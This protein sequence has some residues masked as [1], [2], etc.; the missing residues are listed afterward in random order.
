[1]KKIAR[2]LY[3]FAIVFLLAGFGIGI[4]R[5]SVSYA[6]QAESRQ[7]AAVATATPE[8]SAVEGC[9]ILDTVVDPDARIMHTVAEATEPVMKPASPVGELTEQDGQIADSIEKTA[10]VKKETAQPSMEPTEEPSGPTV[11]PTDSITQT[12]DA[13]KETSQPADDP[14]EPT[15]QPFDET[16]EP[17]SP[18]AHPVEE[19]KDEGDSSDQALAAAIALPTAT[20]TEAPETA[21]PT[22]ILPTESLAPS[23]EIKASPIAI[24]TAIPV[25][26][27]P[28]PQKAGMTIHYIGYCAANGLHYGK[29]TNTGSRPAELGYRYMLGSHRVQSLG[30]FRPGES[31]IIGFPRRGIIIRYYRYDHKWIQLKGYTR[32]FGWGQ[33]CPFVTPTP[34]SVPPTA[35]PTEVPPTATPTEVPPT[36][37]PT[38]VPPTETPTEV[39]PTETPTEVP[40]TETPTE[41]PPTE[42]P[43]EVPPTETPT[44][45]PPTETPTEVPPTETPTEVPPTETPTEVPPTETPTEVPPTETPTEVPPTEMPTEIPPTATPTEVP[46]TETPTEVP[47]ATKVSPTM[48]PAGALPTATPIEVQSAAGSELPIEGNISIR[49][50]VVCVR[51][52]GDG[53]FAAF[54]GYRNDNPHTVIIPI[55]PENEFS[56]APIN[57]GQPTVFT[58]STENLAD[59]GVFEVAFADDSLKW[60]V[61]GHMAI[62]DEHAPVCPAKDEDAA[63]S[64]ASAGG[65]ELLIPVTGGDQMAA[66]TTKGSIHINIVLCLIGLAMIMQGIWIYKKVS[67]N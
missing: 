23:A 35:T 58:A 9:L 29:V 47:P 11:E 62:A 55:G 20:L 34:T 27:I 52:N 50:V 1:M 24:L 51:N 19:D 39:P 26:A 6:S 65:Q 48:T 46:P 12:A 33:W 22:D 5:P 41:V 63:I 32:F 21:K 18:D 60:T 61:Q 44:K 64:N 56:P 17:A 43:T 54:F 40:P 31:K 66:Q 25:T 10:D 38:E 57:R 28:V 30:K 42:T 15:E 4:T 53:T 59:D 36:A 37:T 3:F 2:I 49:P 67:E 8:D 45:V 14:I 13:A 7:M 16:K